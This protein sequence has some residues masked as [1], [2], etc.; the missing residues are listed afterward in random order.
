MLEITIIGVLLG[1]IG[2]LAVVI[3]CLLRK[4]RDAR[5]QVVSWKLAAEH[6]E[7]EAYRS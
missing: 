6:W 5:Q 2:I 1:V 3:Q 7:R 4:L